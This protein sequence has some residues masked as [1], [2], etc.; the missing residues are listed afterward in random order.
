M[1]R[2]MLCKEYL[3]NLCVLDLSDN[4]LG[5]QG[6]GEF[7]NGSDLNCMVQIKALDLCHNHI[8]DEG[9]SIIYLYIRNRQWRSLEHLY[10]DGSNSGTPQS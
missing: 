2:G 8:T 6:V 9:A 10:L 5:D 7:G 1:I 4:H 3:P